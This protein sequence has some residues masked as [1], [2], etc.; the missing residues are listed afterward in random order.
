[1]YHYLMPAILDQW[2]LCSYIC[3]C[4]SHCI[5]LTHFLFGSFS[6]GRKSQLSYWL[7]NTAAVM[8]SER[9]DSPGYFNMTTPWQSD[10]IINFPPNI[11]DSLSKDI[12]SFGAQA[13]RQPSSVCWVVDAHHIICPELKCTGSYY[14]DIGWIWDHT[15]SAHRT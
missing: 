4:P 1:M 7:I 6:M 2:L 10:D 15:T 12:D 5:W 8:S 9:I 11:F 13:K 14:E 3:P